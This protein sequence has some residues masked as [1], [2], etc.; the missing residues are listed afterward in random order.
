LADSALSYLQQKVKNVQVFADVR[1]GGLE[2]G[3]VVP[4]GSFLIAPACEINF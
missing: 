1:V 2:D 3:F 4:G